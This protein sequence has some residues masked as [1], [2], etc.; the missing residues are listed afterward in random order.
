MS[1]DLEALITRLRR[2][3]VA[4]VADQFDKL[5]QVPPVLSREL[6]PIGQAQRFAGP[7]F[8]IEGRKLN[9]SGWLAMTTGRDLLY[10]S[11]DERVPSGTVLLY[12]TGGY[13][14]AAVFGGSTAAALQRRGVAGAIIDGAVRD[15]E[16]IARCGL[17]LLA[18]TV[19]AFRFMGRF[20]VTAVD[21]PI[22]LRGLA[23]SVPAAPG[24]LV[25]AD[26]DGAIVIPIGL[27]P[28]IIEGAERAAA[29]G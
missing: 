25:L 16:A 8:C 15:T 19:S 7:A 11:L 21:G 9:T 14:D 10:D 23:G 3:T 12:A 13:D 28:G 5:G 27:A 29:G 22:G 6:R 2:L 26:H 24:D 18:R 17:P 4:D 1:S 20:A